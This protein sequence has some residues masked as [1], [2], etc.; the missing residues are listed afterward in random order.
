MAIRITRASSEHYTELFGKMR[1]PEVGWT[2]SRILRFWFRG[3]FWF[4]ADK[5]LTCTTCARML[6]IVFLWSFVVKSDTFLQR[7]CQ[8]I[9]WTMHTRKKFFPLS[10]R[11]GGR[12]LR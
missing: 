8:L 9:E 10:S 6:S 5:N 1:T 4:Y 2:L 11:R 7:E 12:D 3:G